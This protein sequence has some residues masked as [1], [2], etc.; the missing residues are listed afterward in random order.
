M[1]AIEFTVVAGERS[2]SAR[3][4]ENWNEARSWGHIVMYLDDDERAIKEAV[5]VFEEL[6]RKHL[7]Q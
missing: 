1:K 3:G 2:V 4:A 6:L 5:S 7:E